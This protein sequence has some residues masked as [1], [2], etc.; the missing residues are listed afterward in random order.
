[1]NETKAF[2]TFALSGVVC[3]LFFQSVREQS[4]ARSGTA[5]FDK[6]SWAVGF[7]E[8]GCQLRWGIFYF[9]ESRDQMQVARG[10][11]VGEVVKVSAV[12]MESPRET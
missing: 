7:V 2:Q 11:V 10:G 3:F 5:G 6:T 12:G 9:L 8:A 4:F 1:M